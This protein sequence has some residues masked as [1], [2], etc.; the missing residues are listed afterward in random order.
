M[1]YMHVGTYWHI[2]L[3]GTCSGRIILPHV[4]RS[5][6]VL[7][8]GTLK[9]RDW[10]KQEAA[11][12]ALLPGIAFHVSTLFEDKL[13]EQVCSTWHERHDLV[14]RYHQNHQIP[15]C[16]IMPMDSWMDLCWLRLQPSRPHVLPYASNASCSPASG[17]GQSNCKCHWQQLD[18]AVTCW[19]WN[20]LVTECYR[21]CRPHWTQDDTG[22]EVSSWIPCP[23]FPRDGDRWWNSWGSLWARRGYCR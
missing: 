18:A 17:A 22:Y 3:L 1:G 2:L 8:S 9:Q 21:H 11:H 6:H 5:F 23:S 16:Q 14:S 7:L 10:R 19:F 12:I 13:V 15:V 20:L 4:A